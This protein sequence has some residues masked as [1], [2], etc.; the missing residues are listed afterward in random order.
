M[1]GGDINVLAM[2]TPLPLAYGFFRATGNRRI[3]YQLLANEA[4]P[5]PANIQIGVW[6]LGEGELDGVNAL[7]INDTLQFAY[8]VH[9]ALMG[10]SLLGVA[11][12]GSGSD[13]IETTPTL[14]TF[15]FHTGCDAPVYTGSSP[16]YS[17]TSQLL[18]PIWTFSP[19]G[20]A[21]SQL[22]VL[23]TPMC[24]SRRSYYTIAWTPATNDQSDISPV[25]DMRGMRCRIFDSAGNQTAYGFTTNPIWHAVDLWLRRAIKPWYAIPQGAWPDPLTAAELSLFNWPSIAAAAAYCDQLLANGRPRFSG[26][27]VFASG[28]T[29]MAMLEQVMLCCRGY[30][31]EYAGQI[32]MFI[33]QPRSSTCLI[34]AQALASGSFEHD[35]QDVNQAPNRYVAEFLEIGLPAVAAIETITS[36]PASGD[37]SAAVA[38]VTEDPNPCATG[39]LISVGGVT[40]AGFDAN[41]VVSSTPSDVD[42]DCNVASAASASGTGGSIGYIQSRFS[43][44]TPEISHVQHQMAQGQILPPTTAGTRLKRIKVNYNFANMTYDQAMRLLQYEVYRELGIDW[45]NPTLLTLVYGN[46]AL[47]GSEWTPPWQITVNLFSEYVDA[48]GNAVKA[49]QVGDIVTLDPTVFYEFAGEYEIIQRTHNPFQ[50]EVDD[51]TG[52]GFI[53]PTTRAGAQGNGTDQNSG[54]LTLVLR[55]FNQSAAIFTDVSFP[56]PSWPTVPGQLPYAGVGA[57]GW[58]ALGSI[59]IDFVTGGWDTEF[60][61]PYTVSFTI[62]LTSITLNIPPGVVV[63]YGT[64]S[65][66]GVATPESGDQ[67]VEWFIYVDDPTFSGSDSCVFCAPGPAPAP[68]PGI[69]VIASFVCVNP[70][71]PSTVTITL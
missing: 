64:F 63:S 30:W 16:G 32:Y 4:T 51:S 54:I 39:D 49:Q 1:P 3:D 15:S 55:T 68:G 17:A 12:T 10:T 61:G 52:G 5:Q 50:E 36:T 28:S 46:T 25:L 27:Y 29:L 40:P 62:Y 19:A 41:Y 69:Y 13:T 67:G 59:V 26:S 18:D 71:P 48:A 35:D 57:S 34:T 53:V 45:L 44:R 37:T 14:N 56:N 58:E 6:D 21:P 23:E 42:V 9:G 70:G 65:L 31:Y 38:I 47:L 11:P 66:G 2:G 24:Y 20:Y 8:D 22:S 60:E 33:D 43:Q 7:W